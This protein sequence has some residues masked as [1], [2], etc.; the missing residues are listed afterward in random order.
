MPVGLSK[1]AYLF[2]DIE[3]L[4]GVIEIGIPV[5]TF[6]GGFPVSSD[7]AL[8]FCGFMTPLPIS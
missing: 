4:F 3:I 5:N 6:E 2:G 8:M 7:D 1:L